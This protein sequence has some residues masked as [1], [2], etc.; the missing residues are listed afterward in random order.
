MSTIT[1]SLSGSA[2]AGLTSNPSKIYTIDDSDLQLLL[3]WV[4]VQWAG[5]LGLS[6]T[7]AQLLLAWIQYQLV[8]PTIQGVQITNRTTPPPISLS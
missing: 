7:N 4:A 2:I 5:M 3:N 8:A 1:I 6:P